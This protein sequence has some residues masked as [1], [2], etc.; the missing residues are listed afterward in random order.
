[1]S[2]S[3]SQTQNFEKGLTDTQV[4]TGA[5]GNKETLAPR[6]GVSQEVA[7]VTMFTRGQEEC[8]VAL[9]APGHGRMPSFG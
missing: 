9:G 7:F 3:P 8:S 1:M 4:D 6:Q 2:S 5:Q